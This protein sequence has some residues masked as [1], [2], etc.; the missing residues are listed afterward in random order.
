MKNFKNIHVG[1]SA[2]VLTN[3]A[4]EQKVKA[5]PI[6]VNNANANVQDEII[7]WGI[8]NLYPQNIYNKKFLF[9]GA[10]VGG[11]DV[12]KS[13][14]YGNGFALYK[15]TQPDVGG[16]IVK[17]RELLSKHSEI[18][19]F[20][21]SNKLHRF[22]FGKLTDLSLFQIS[23]TEH[24]LSK[25]QDKIVLVKRH[26][27]ANCR[28]MP[29]D[30][31]GIIP[32]IYVNT[33]WQN[34][35]PKYTVKIPFM[36]PEL[37]AVEIKQHCKDKRIF[38]FMTVTCYPL[39]TESYYPQADWHAVD[40]NG[41]MQVANAV[42]ELKQAIFE[43][44]LHFKY[45]VYVSDYYFENYYKDEWD[46]FDAAKRQEMR[47][48]LATAIDDHMSGNKAGGRSLTSPIFEDGGKFVKGI[49]VHPID[50]KLKDGSYLPDASA[51]NSEILFAIGVDPSIIGAGIPGSGSQS[52]SGSDKR[53]AYTILSAR[54]TP[55][56]HI[57][58]DDWE[59]WRDFNGWDQDLEATFPNVNLTTLDKNPDGA[60]EV[61]R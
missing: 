48:Q 13:T 57:A 5:M 17:R 15:E 31:K 61:I 19:Q 50:N 29:M 54:L 59:L 36:N 53:E 38:N 9:N 8:D 33:D 52:R 7:P 25:N 40:R 18:Q 1:K 3:V 42:P 26:Q 49:E 32:F 16:D 44:Q 27:A 39:V 58:L 28:F 47:E 56:R 10:A 46:D 34:Y 45:I 55:K 14:F 23:F 4:Q 11:I 60:V 22:W 41:W 12:L 43:N 35:D 37:T 20:I 51:A 30:E 6:K 24:V 21:R 2:V